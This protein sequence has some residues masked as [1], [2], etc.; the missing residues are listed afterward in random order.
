MLR[1]LVGSEMCIR[2]SDFRI[3]DSI[4]APPAVEP[5]LP[6]VVET[7]VDTREPQTSTFEQVSNV[8][9]PDFASNTRH[10]I[11]EMSQPTETVVEGQLY[12]DPVVLYARPRRDN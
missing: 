12:E 4:T 11:P 2:D 8:A 6:E 9:T 7:E 1:S 5:E 3:P 10:F